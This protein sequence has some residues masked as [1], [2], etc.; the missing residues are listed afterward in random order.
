[1]SNS[2]Y[3]SLHKLVDYLLKKGIMEAKDISKL[4]GIPLKDFIAQFMEK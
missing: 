3:E 4:L 2:S 1:V